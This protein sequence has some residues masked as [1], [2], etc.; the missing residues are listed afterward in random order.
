MEQ[1]TSSDGAFIVYRRSGA[2]PPLLL[3][4]G[5]TADHRSWSAVAPLLEPHFTLY[6]MDRRGRGE[7]GDTADYGLEREVADIIAVI[8][9][10]GQPVNVLG[11]SYGALCCLEA[12]LQTDAIARLILY[13]PGLA[14]GIELYPPGVPERM[15]ALID[16]G[17]LEGAMVVMFREVV[18]MPEPELAEY[19]HSSLWAARLP[20]ARTIPREMAAELGYHFNAARFADL[21]TPALLLTGGDSPA[22]LRQATALVHAALPNSRVAV[23]PGQQHIAYRTAPELF[24]AAVLVFLKS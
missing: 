5:T 9:A 17:D 11:H 10:I 6:A 1:V 14:T 7:S 19:R 24:T 3:V 4:H 16:G 2:G 13:E 20:L 21:R 8:E 23:L 18:R 22:V 12:A 15:Q